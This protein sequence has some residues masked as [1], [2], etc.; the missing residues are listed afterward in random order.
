MLRSPVF[1]FPSF[2][3][4]SARVV[5]EALACGCY[6]ITTPNSGT[7]VEHGVHGAL[8]PPGNPA[9]LAQSVKDA[10]AD[11]NRLAEIGAHNAALVR[12]QYT[13]SAYGNA[14]ASLYDEVRCP[15]HR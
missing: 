14:L 3:E 13:Q 15:S 11:R 4:G 9:A 10:D 1:I 8:V 5:F 2:A 7:I 12:A 6:V